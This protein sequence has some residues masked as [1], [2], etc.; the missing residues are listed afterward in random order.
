MCFHV[1][2]LICLFDMWV[3]ICILLMNV[4]FVNINFQNFVYTFRDHLAKIIVNIVTMFVTF[5]KLHGLP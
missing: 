1:Y 3:C 2:A 4:F 5:D